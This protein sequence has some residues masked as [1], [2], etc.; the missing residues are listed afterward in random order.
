MVSHGKKI[1]SACGILCK[2][3][4]PGPESHGLLLGNEALWQ[5]SI[6]QPLDEGG[7]K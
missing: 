2:V 4:K 3:G 5:F 1:D 7:D 6:F